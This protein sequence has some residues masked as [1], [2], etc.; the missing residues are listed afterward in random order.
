LGN[1]LWNRIRIP[2][3]SFSQPAW[4]TAARPFNPGSVNALRFAWYGEG[5][6]RFDLDNVRIE[7]MKIGPAGI[8]SRPGRRRQSATVSAKGS[9]LRFPVPS[10]APAFSDAQGRLAK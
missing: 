7:G 3:T 5:T 10:G 9:L 1:D 4:K 6:V 8:K 2:L